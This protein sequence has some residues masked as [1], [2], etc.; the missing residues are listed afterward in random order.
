MRHV[1]ILIRCPPHQEAELGLLGMSLEV[2]RFL[3]FYVSLFTWL[4]HAELGTAWVYSWPFCT[5]VFSG[6]FLLTWPQGNTGLE[7]LLVFLC[8]LSE[9]SGFVSMRGGKMSHQSLRVQ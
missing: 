5:L 9:Q 7:M 4:A 6:L 8:Q 2:L 3:V 1:L